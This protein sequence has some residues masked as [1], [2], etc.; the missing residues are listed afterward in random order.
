MQRQQTATLL[1]ESNDEV[2]RRGVAPATN[3]A[4]LSRSSTPLLG[5]PK[6]RPRDR[7]NRLLEVTCDHANIQGAD[8]GAQPL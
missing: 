8:D 6:M 3:G 5:L 1:Q 2:E 7:S 4:D